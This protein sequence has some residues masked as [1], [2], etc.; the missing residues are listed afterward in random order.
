MGLLESLKNN[1][2]SKKGGWF[3][4]ILGAL[5]LI[6]S[7]VTW[8]EE[9][10]TL[11]LFAVLPDYVPLIFSILFLIIGIIFVFFLKK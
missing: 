8:G 6:M 1:I 11:T 7:I 3:C 10:S 9:P 5:G 2:S 4:L